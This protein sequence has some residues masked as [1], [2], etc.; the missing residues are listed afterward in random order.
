MVFLL[1]Y[2][3]ILQVCMCVSEREKETQKREL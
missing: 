1:F 3:L 2:V